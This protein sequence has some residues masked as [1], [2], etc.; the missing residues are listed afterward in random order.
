VDFQAFYDELEKI[1]AAGKIPFSPR[2]KKL[3][4]GSL[5]RRFRQGTKPSTA[6]KFKSKREFR[7]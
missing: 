6:T 5:G 2:M 4:Q 1:A 3:F 7:T